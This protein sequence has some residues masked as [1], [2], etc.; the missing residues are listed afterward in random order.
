MFTNTKIQVGEGVVGLRCNIL[1]S[2][3]QSGGRVHVEYKT[4]DLN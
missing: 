2:K 1:A 3:A 4:Y